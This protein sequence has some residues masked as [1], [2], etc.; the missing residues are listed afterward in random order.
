MLL[1]ELFSRPGKIKNK[2]TGTG[3]LHNGRLFKKGDEEMTFL[4]LLEQV[5]IA[6]QGTA[7]E[8]AGKKV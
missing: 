3:P 8:R 4:L 6:W 1:F 5:S 2:L 7:R